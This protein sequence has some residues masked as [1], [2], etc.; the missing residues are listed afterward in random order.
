MIAFLRGRLASVDANQVVVDV[1]GVGYSLAV[2]A[3]TLDRLPATGR[4]VTLHTSLQV[5]EDAWSLYGFAT[6]E[7]RRAF[8]L[9]VGVNGVGPRLALAVLS[10][11]GPAG[12]AQAVLLEDAAALARVPGVGKKTAQRLILELR[13]KLG[14]L[15]EAG[16]APAAPTAEAGPAGGGDAFAEAAAALAALG[17]SGAEAAR[18]VEAA[19]RRLPGGGA[20]A[21]V[22][23]IV[24]QSLRELAR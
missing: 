15:D 11:L 5:R 24:R 4:E 20:D 19:R 23:V 2:P 13:G 12:L 8:E 9:L 3:G 18:A 21:D 6:P 14:G 7:E 22:E 16:L 10:G 17:Y 1:G